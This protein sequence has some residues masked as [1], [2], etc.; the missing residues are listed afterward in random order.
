VGEVVKSAI[1]LG[2]GKPE[3]TLYWA[4]PVDSHAPRLPVRLTKRGPRVPSRYEP[5]VLKTMQ[6]R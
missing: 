6:E 1:R 2:S 3:V 4:E 5:A